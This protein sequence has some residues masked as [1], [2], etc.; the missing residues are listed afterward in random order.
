MDFG[1]NLNW[2]LVLRTS[3]LAQIVPEAR[4]GFLP[5]PNKIIEVD[6]YTLAIGVSS[7][8]AK[9]TWKRGAFVAP[10]LLFSVSSTSEYAG[11]VRS[12]NAKA[13]FLNQLTLVQFE[14]FGI[15]PYALEIS[16]PFWIA[17]LN[18][19]IWKYQGIDNAK[20]IQEQIAEVRSD[21]D[22][23]ELKIDNYSTS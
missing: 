12:D 16:I 14:D 20:P 8:K 22:R 6:R 7:T 18:I 13:V 17:Q 2:D 10:R 5:I 4:R 15:T 1:N 21:L 23:I 3:Y 19:E 9:P 11:L